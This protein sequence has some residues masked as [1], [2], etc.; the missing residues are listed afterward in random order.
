MTYSLAG[1]TVVIT[2]A[3]GGLGAALARGLRERAANLALLDLDGEAVAAHADDLGGDRVARGWQADVRSLDSLDAAIAGAAAHFG[4]VDV[5]IAGAA[6]ADVH[7]PLSA[8]S[9]E[10][11]EREIDI[12]L[13]GVW[14]TFKA[15]LPHVAGQRGHLSAIASMASFTHMPFLSSY[16]ASKAGVWGMCDSLRLEL[17]GSGVTVGSVHPSF[18]RTPMIDDS[19]VN[20]ALGLLF[21]NFQG[22]FKMVDIDAVVEAIISGI[23]RRAPHVVIPKHLRPAAAAPGV[24]RPILER[25]GFP[26]TRIKRIA[27]LYAESASAAS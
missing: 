12:N 10:D 4:R 16:S 7:G 2:G 23:E 6:I 26:R 20:P 21:N 25:L 1:R 17:R 8:T 3:A 22:M 14:R 15:A 11:W 13:N 18:F 27:E 9:V 19:F 24:L 5:A